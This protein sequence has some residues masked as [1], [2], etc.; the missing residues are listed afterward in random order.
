MCIEHRKDYTL[1]EDVVE[2]AHEN[3]HRGDEG[4]TLCWETQVLTKVM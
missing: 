2:K 3:L 4:P 1:M